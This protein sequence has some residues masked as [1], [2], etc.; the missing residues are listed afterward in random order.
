M[1]RQKYILLVFI[2]LGCG[3]SEKYINLEKELS[4]LKKKQEIIINEK[5]KKEQEFLQLKKQH[6]I[7][8]LD[9]SRLE[10]EIS[11][12]SNQNK[13]TDFENEKQSIQTNDLKKQ[14]IN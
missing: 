6:D 5:E 3:P 11:K 4:D 14:L 12:A 10:I 8:L 13:I 9:K 7:L 2:F 1:N